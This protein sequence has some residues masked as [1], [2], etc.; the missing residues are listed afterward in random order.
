MP[1]RFSGGHYPADRAGYSPDVADPDVLSV[2]SGSLNDDRLPQEDSDIVALRF[3]TTANWFV[4]EA[5]ILESVTPD[6]ACDV[7]WGYKLQQYDEP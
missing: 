3:P 7:F 2:A 4:I 1:K 5:R 6:I